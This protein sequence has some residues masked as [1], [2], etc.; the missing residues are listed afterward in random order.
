MT[1]PHDQPLSRRAARRALEAEH[2]GAESFAQPPTESASRS[3]SSSGTPTSVPSSAPTDMTYRTQ[4][5]P[6][7]PH[8]DERSMPVAPVVEQ[9]IEAP[10][11]PP[12]VAPSA[13]PEHG[14]ERVRRRDFRPPAATDEPRT[15]VAAA[16][17][18][19][20][21]EY[22]TQLTPRPTVTPSTTAQAPP[23]A[24][25]IDTGFAAIERTA[26][27]SGEQTMSR[28][29]L[30]ELRAAHL[31]AAPAPLV[32]QSPPAP[33][34][35]DSA[36]PHVEPLQVQQAPVA[37]TVVEPVLVEPPR[38][39][40]GQFAPVLIEPVAVEPELVHPVAVEHAPVVPTT[41]GSHW[42]TGIH[43]DE[44][45]FENTFSREVGSAT[46]LN[47]NALVLPEMPTG[48]IAG[49]VAGTG[50]IIVTGMIAVS[51][52]HSSTGTVPTLHDSPDID[53]LFDAEDR[54]VAAPDSA[55]VSALKAISSHTSSHTVMTGKPSSS[56][57]IT[58][59]LVASTV[60]M[61]VIAIGLF[62]VAA[63]NG[64]F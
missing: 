30:R 15:H 26:D 13:L 4:V 27:T 47:T 46:S 44:D 51:P 31:A 58:T 19:T 64:L 62:V 48:S 36:P 10:Q 6:R 16:T 2:A 43:D 11:S 53:D 59:V 35:S 29:E 24:H 5:R 52:L 20:P 32:E 50:E 40:S 56:N 12:P 63:A 61:A 23:P 28:R 9:A 42:S 37:P 21:L 55:P 60:G 17:F 41:T 33:A 45:P 7:V 34:P 54:E 14:A 18:D 39:E 49:P 25:V 3:Q 57:T 22:H 38:V 8:Y 1:S